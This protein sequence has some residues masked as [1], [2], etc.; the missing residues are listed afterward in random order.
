MN[1]QARYKY[2]LRRK[3]LL[4]RLNQNANLQESAQLGE[5]N[6]K[7]FA[8]PLEAKTFA[9]V[10]KEDKCLGFIVVPH[11][12]LTPSGIRYRTSFLLHSATFP[13]ITPHNF[14]SITLSDENGN[15]PYGNAYL[16]QKFYPMA[17]Q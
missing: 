6:K 3:N 13:N 14:L 10:A 1:P 7:L 5:L 17:L 15:P 16:L 2:I 11:V 12:S 9:D 4:I 8:A